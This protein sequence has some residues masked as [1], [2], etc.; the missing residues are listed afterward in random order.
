[1]KNETPSLPNSY[2]WTWDHSCN[3]C[4]DDPGMQTSG[5]YNP[6]LKRPE[7]FLEDYRRLTDHAANLGIKGIVIWGFLRDSHGGIDYAKRVADYAASKGVAILPGVGTTWYG[8]VYYEGDSPYSLTTFL[9]AHPDARMLDDKGEPLGF[10]GHHGACLAHPAYQAWLADSIDWLFREF[11]IGGVNLENGDFLV[12]HH[13]L[14]KALRQNWP[15][16][17]PEVFF[18]QGMSYKQALDRMAPHLKDKLCAYAT[19]SGFQKTASAVQNAGMGGKAPAMFTILPPL[20]IAQWTLSG[21][22]RDKPLPLTDYLDNGQPEAV[23]DNPN[24]PRGLQ[25]PGAR[26]VGFL[27]QGS[28][29]W[30]VGRYACIVST[31]KEACLRA[32]ESGLEGVSIHGEVTGRH[33]PYA[34]NYLA[35]SHFTKRPQDTL[36]DFG[37]QALGKVLGSE[38]AG[39]DFAV[40]LA[41]WDAGTLT[42]DLRKLALPASH[43]FSQAAW[44][45]TCDT[46]EDYQRFRYWEWLGNAVAGKATDHSL[47]V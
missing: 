2:F 5:C 35:F 7:T 45:S 40:V 33:I 3:W 46:L 4:L 27:H 24:W 26:N 32:S 37:R 10:N 30:R 42:D 39:E 14:V 34:L 16:D 41:H 29:W 21:M 12:D 9:K 43:G 1:L 31:I 11:N 36:R 20:G 44:A 15:A 25:P 13:P 19:Y 47:P 22:L 17:D 28:Q 18:H 23:Y 38:Q 8:G 6:Y